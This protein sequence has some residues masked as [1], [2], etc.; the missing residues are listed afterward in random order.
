MK[1]RRALSVWLA[2]AVLVL[3]LVSGCAT[4]SSD[5]RTDETTFVLGEYHVQC[6]K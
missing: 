1:K 4:P 3:G 5:T 2:A 6:R